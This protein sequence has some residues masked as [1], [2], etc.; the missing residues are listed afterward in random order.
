[1]EA[2]TTSKY[3]TTIIAVTPF[4]IVTSLYIIGIRFHTK[5]IQ[6]SIREKDLTWKLDITN[7]VILVTHYSHSIVMHGLTYLIPNLHEQTGNWFCYT[8]KAF[9]YYG[10]LYTIGHSMVVSILKYIIIVQWE[11][12]RNHGNQMVAEILFWFNF[13]HPVLN[14]VVH[15]FVRP[16]FLWIYDGISN[17]NR[18]LG[19]SVGIVSNSSK[20]SNMK[21]HHLCNIVEPIYSYSIEYGIFIARKSI[22]VLQTLNIYLMAWN[23]IEIFLYCQI[24]AFARR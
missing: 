6:I 24:F 13:L 19:E 9:A 23:I 4:L 12:V 17:S 2:E 21:L 16:D 20:T 7:S 1:M 18:C 5:I 14:I 22:C 10:N 11:K 8:Y 15:L 3:L